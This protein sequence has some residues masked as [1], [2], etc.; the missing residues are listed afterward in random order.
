MNADKRIIETATEL[1]LKHGVR[2]ITMND[3][4]AAMGISKK[5]LYEHFINKDE[6]LDKCI[7]YIR[8][9]GEKERN[10]LFSKGGINIE[11]MLEL[12]RNSALRINS[13]NPNFITDIKKYHPGI[14]VKINKMEAESIQF[15]AEMIIDGIK[16]GLFRSDLNVDIV[17]KLLH[18]SINQ[19]MNT[20]L[21]PAERF[22]RSEVF[23][24]I[25]DIF[26]RGISTEKALKELKRIKGDYSDN[27]DIF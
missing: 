21:F 14:Y 6:L 11:S 9:H 1:F 12:V 3:I 8:Q 10:E 2:S 15:K 25:M 20:D 16:K 4:A 5:T 18:E 24:T 19:L 26:I 23:R 22:S 17:S 7:N 13:I 27:T